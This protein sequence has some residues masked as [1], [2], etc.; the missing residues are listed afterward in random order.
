[1]FLLRSAIAACAILG[2][3]ACTTL[4]PSGSAGEVK[5]LAAMDYPDKAPHGEDFEVIVT[6][7]DR[8][9]RL[10]HMGTQTY[11][12]GVLWINKQY[13]CQ[14]PILRVGTDNEVDLTTCIN[15]HREPFPVGHLLRPDLDRRVV[16][17]EWFDP[18][19]NT[20]HRL[21]ARPPRD[22]YSEK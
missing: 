1:M 5:G 12:D 20:R 6:R 4:P 17:V 13:A 10:N 9:I 21:V 22:P 14:L 16:L 2:F 8:C 7:E 15:R 19:K 11:R 3:T 18:A